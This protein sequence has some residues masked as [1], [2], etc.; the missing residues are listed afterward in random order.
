VPPQPVF[1]ID[2]TPGRLVRIAQKGVHSI[3]VGNPVRR[4]RGGRGHPVRLPTTIREMRSRPGW[5][6]P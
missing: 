3:V 5:V 4:L 2:P 1:R 6:V